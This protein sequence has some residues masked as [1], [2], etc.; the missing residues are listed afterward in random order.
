MEEKLVLWARSETIGSAGKGA[1][2]NDGIMGSW[3]DGFKVRKP[4]C[5]TLIARLLVVVPNMPLF[6]HSN[7]PVCPRKRFAHA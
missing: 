7:I 4:F 2:W 6:Q 1:S 3:N 5:G